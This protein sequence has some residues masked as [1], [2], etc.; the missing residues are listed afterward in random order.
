[1]SPVVMNI[2]KQLNEIENIM[3]SI[4]LYSSEAPPHHAFSS[5]LP[6]CCDQ[7]LFHEWLQWVLIPSTRYLLAENKVLPYRNHIFTVAE[8]EMAGLPQDTDDLLSAIHTLDEL[9]R[10][11]YP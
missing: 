2:M 10:Q 6:F 1:M 4:G 7:M 11:L 9:F 8:T 5:N 3:R